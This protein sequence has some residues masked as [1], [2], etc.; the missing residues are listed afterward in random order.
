MRPLPPRITVFINLS[1]TDTIF[2]TLITA[3]VRIIFGGDFLKS[4]VIKLNRSVVVKSILVCLFLL[5]TLMVIDFTLISD[6]FGRDISNIFWADKVK[7]QNYF[8]QKINLIP[9]ATIKLYINAYKAANLE[10]HIILENILGNFLVFM[11]FAFLI[12]NVFRAVNSFAKFLL[13][14]SVGV[15]IIEILQIV[16]LTGSADIDDFI[17]NVSGSVLAYGVFN[18]RKIKQSINKFLFGEVNEIESKRKNKSDA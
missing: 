1:Q 11:P 15:M 17:L 7:I 6:I 9:F 18:I 16:F 3:K 8:S 5:Y 2:L 10:M 12:P 4:R 13:C 14:I